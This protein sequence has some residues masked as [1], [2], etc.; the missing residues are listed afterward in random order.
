MYFKRSKAT[1]VDVASTNQRFFS[2]SPAIVKHHHISGGGS[3]ETKHKIPSA[4]LYYT[5]KTST[6]YESTSWLS[7]LILNC[8]S[9]MYVW[10]CSPVTLCFTGPGFLEI[11]LVREASSYHFI[12]PG[13][14]VS[15]NLVDRTKSLGRF[16]TPPGCEY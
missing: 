1:T 16:Y 8:A 9:P 4:N 14:T 12:I 7:F 10:P 5:R 13:A 15:W 6:G 11:Y 2:R 3:K